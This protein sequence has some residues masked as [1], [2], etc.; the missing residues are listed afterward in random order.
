MEVKSTIRNF[1][2]DHCGKAGEIAYIEADGP[3]LHQA[4]TWLRLQG[5]GDKDE[6]YCNHSCLTI[7]VGRIKCTPQTKLTITQSLVRDK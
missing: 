3:P 2:C 5:N 6:D 4:G 1:K 7:I